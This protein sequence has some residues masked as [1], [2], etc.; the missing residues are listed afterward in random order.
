M[1]KKKEFK[2]LTS[3]YSEH[4][5]RGINGIV[6]RYCHRKLECFK[7]KEKYDNVLEIRAGTVPHIDYIKYK[8]DKYYIAGVTMCKNG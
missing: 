4:I 1:Y 6:M 2:K 3:S 7:G 8:F 5:Y